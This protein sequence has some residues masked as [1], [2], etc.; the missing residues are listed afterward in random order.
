[1]MCNIRISIN[2]FI[3]LVYDHQT[4]SGGVLI[5]HCASRTGESTLGNEVWTSMTT[6]NDSLTHGREQRH[7][8]W[9]DG[10]KLYNDIL[11]EGM[12][13]TEQR[14]THWRDVQKLSNDILTE[15]M[16]TK[17]ATAYSLKGWTKTERRHTHWGNGHKVS[18]GILTEGMDRRWVTT[19]SL[20]RGSNDKFIHKREQR[21]THLVEVHTERRT[22]FIHRE[23]EHGVMMNN[24]VLLFTVLLILLMNVYKITSFFTQYFFA[25]YI[26]I[27]NS[28]QLLL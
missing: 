9:G 18:N 12:D 2:T 5:L 7:T 3:E 13:T 17:W 26:I 15:G 23:E 16:D 10:Q 19:N 1:M 25:I 20:I 21:H 4:I 24:L 14:H 11:T 6:S 28:K 8:H 22:G 27:L